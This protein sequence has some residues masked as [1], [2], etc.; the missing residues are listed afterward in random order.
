MPMTHVQPATPAS[1]VQ[2]T[3]LR[4]VDDAHEQRLEQEVKS[5]ARKVIARL[6]RA[7]LLED[8]PM[9]DA[10]HYQSMLAQLALAQL[11]LTY[12]RALLGTCAVEG[13]HVRF[14][15]EEDGLYVRCVAPEGHGWKIG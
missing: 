3:P 12:P 14:V 9:D 4:T 6:S 2:E 5:A 13:A 15:A 10:V 1:I 8:L 11:A 7:S